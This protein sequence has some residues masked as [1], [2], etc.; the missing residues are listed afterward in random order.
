MNGGKAETSM[1]YAELHGERVPAL[2]LGT[3]QLTGETCRR[4]VLN[5][6]EL[7]YTHIDT[8]QMYGNEDAIGSALRESK[9]EREKLFI[10]TKIGWDHLGYDAVMTAFEQCLNKLQRDYVNLLLIHWPSRS[11]PLEETLAAFNELRSKGGARQI[12][13]SNFPSAILRKATE[14]SDA[15]VFCNQVEYHPYL[16][17]DKVLKVCRENQ[18]MLTAYS[19][20]A[21]GEVVGDDVLNEIGS[22]YG[23]SAA[24]VTLRW[25]L[26]QKLVCAVPKAADPEHLESNLNVFD[27]EL[28][29]DDMVLIAGLEKEM[30]LISPSL[31]PE[32]DK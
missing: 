26:Q 28:T 17:Q 29:D 19:P 7:G 20:L 2:G 27:F 9:S 3:W 13:V 8:A 15:P 18:V 16:S 23:K 14:I 21:R 31:A 12:G 32:W 5:A 10:T 24:Q 22:K 1:I 11:V 25:L 4:S 30:R 6:L